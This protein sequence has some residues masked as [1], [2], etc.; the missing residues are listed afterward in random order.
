MDFGLGL[1]LEFGS[2]LRGVVD[3]EYTIGRRLGFNFYK[4][5][6]GIFLITGLVLL[7]VITSMILSLCID[8]IQL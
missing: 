1:K 5:Q 4:V 3:T 2:G 6:Y 8:F 7:I